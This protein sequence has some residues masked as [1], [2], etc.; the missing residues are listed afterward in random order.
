VG[1]ETRLGRVLRNER[2]A[3]EAE[4]ERPMYAGLI[5]RVLCECGDPD[6]ESS[7]TMPSADYFELRA[8][9][10]FAIAADCKSR[11]AES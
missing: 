4:D 2:L 9:Q 5:L 8:E 6:C 3:R 11:V 1:Y 7:L 10:R